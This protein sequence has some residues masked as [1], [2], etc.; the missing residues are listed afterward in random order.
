MNDIASLREQFP[1]L[2][3]PHGPEGITY[4]DN[5][6]SSL[7]PMPVIEAVT[8]YYTGNGANV[9]RGRHFL[10]EEASELYEGCRQRVARFLNAASAEIVFVQGTTQGINLVAGGLGL[11]AEDNVVGTMLEHHANV[12]PFSRAC[13]YRAAALGKDGLPDVE[14]ARALVDENTRLLT[15]THLSNVTG[16]IVPIGPWSAL[17]REKGIPLLVDAAQAASH[18][19]LDVQELDCD[20]L[21]FSG[22]KI[23]AP[24]GVGILYGRMEALEALTPPWLGGGAVSRVEPDGSFHLR[25]VPWRFE[26]G[27]PPI[28]SVLGLDAALRFVESIGI[29]VIHGRTNQLAAYLFDA[30]AKVPELQPIEFDP[31]AERA[32]I[33]SFTGLRP[34]VAARILS[35]S[36]GVASRGGHHC[37]H[38]FH[39][40]LGVSGSLRYSLHFYNT[41]AEIDHAVSAL[42]S[43]AALMKE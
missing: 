7:R 31:G 40:H 32:P 12:L 26:S 30:V 6:A 2:A 11:K 23:F 5:A 38:P 4:F 15:V 18:L 19:R 35:D 43:T 16:A 36:Y 3:R 41:E 33:I 27:T 28:A 42:A 10:S 21:V 34:D 20:F 37:A 9:H 22:H 8:A 14:A 17:A 39:E 29:S 1:T 13:T 24:S 25:D